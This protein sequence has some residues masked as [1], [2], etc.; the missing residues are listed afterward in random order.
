MRPAA[1]P[2]ISMSKKTLLVTFGPAA[3][4]W[5]VARSATEMIF[6]IDCEVIDVHVA[7]TWHT[8]ITPKSSSNLTAGQL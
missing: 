5:S 6:D 3:T 1:L 8:L 7:D 2:S 4:S